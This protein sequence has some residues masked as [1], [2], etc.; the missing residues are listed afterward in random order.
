MR[1]RRIALLLISCVI[2]FASATVKLFIRPAQGMPSHVSAIVM[3]NGSGNRLPIALDLAWQ[4]R[5]QFVVI[6]RGSPDYAH[7]GNCA[8]PIPRETIIC[9]DPSPS[10]TEG[11]AKYAGRLAR[12]YGWR[13]VVLVTSAPQ[14][15]RAR[16]RFERCFPGSVYAV[17]VPIS[18]SSWPYQVAYE[19]AATIE[20]VAFQRHC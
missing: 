7:G 6:S 9:F 11:E 10:T 3:L 16:L 20:A 4:H 1:R 17:T 8:P 14:D 12:K 18:L 19:W 15:T 13:S 5:A 2:V